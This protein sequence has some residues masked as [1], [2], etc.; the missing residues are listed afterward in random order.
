MTCDKTALNKLYKKP[1]NSLKLMQYR[2]TGAL[3][4]EIIAKDE[5][6]KNGY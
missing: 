6:K 1:W 2:E 5:M 4:D 3:I